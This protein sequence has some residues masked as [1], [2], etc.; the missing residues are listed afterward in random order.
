MTD[1]KQIPFL[2]QLLDDESIDVQ[3]KVSLELDAFGPLLRD[4][5]QK[6][7]FPLTARQKENLENIFEHHQRTRLLQFWPTWYDQ[8]GSMEKLES[9][10]TLL[11]EY[12][13]VYDYRVRL[14][15]LLDELAD[16]FQRKYQSLDP[17]LLAYYLFDEVGMK[18]NDEE[19]YNPQNSNP[20]YVIN[21]KRG[22]P[23]SL[24]CIYMLVGYRVGIP[25]EGCPFPGHFLARIDLDGQM[26]F[27]DCYS[28]GQIILEHEFTKF[29][30]EITENIVE[31]LAERVCAEDIVRRYL[32]NL[33]RAFQ[34]EEDKEGGELMNRLFCD[35][36]QRMA[37]RRI[38]HITPDE[39]IDGPRPK[40]RPG[41][42][43]KHAKYG[44]RGIIVGMDQE[45]KATDDWYYGNQTQ[46]AR[47]QPWF[48]LLVH[49]TE[50]VTYV[51]ENNLEI[52]GSRK[53]IVHPLLT[54]FF[55][56]LGN[57][58]Y[59]RNENAWPQTDF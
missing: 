40:Y 1:P 58:R 21:E 16:K 37:E 26:A 34:F 12:L 27:V 23:I 36:E 10:L 33:I 56:R 4:E 49:D 6:I 52:D 59:V 38:A 17:K 48:H 13:T 39:I 30:D 7:S 31:A 8:R 20:I 43:V 3:E 54:Y 24:V 42:I 51:A 9:A 57:G 15:D 47:D 32:A 45:C 29:R 46:P 28:S 22:I 14:K 44:Y 5:I 50:Q 55:T 41:N 2:V 25:I 11:S 35:L 18:G 53:E 19:Y